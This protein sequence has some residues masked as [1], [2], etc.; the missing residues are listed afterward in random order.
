MFSKWFGDSGDTFF[1]AVQSF[2]VQANGFLESAFE[3]SNIDASW[4][5]GVVGTADTPGMLSIWMPI[6]AIVIAILV[7]IQIA[8]AAYK[9]SGIG[10]LRAVA[11]AAF[12]IPMTYVMIFLVQIFSAG[13]DQATSY[14]LQ[15][16]ATE[17]A[18]VFMKV[19]GVQ[20]SDGE[21]VAVNAKYDMWAAVGE[22]TGGLS[23]LAPLLLM[24]L[25]WL[26]SIVLGVVM[27]LRSM[28]IVILSS[29]AGWAVA[30]LSSDITKSWF[31]G[32]M[33]LIVGLLLAKPF[34]A[35]VI[36]L[37]ATIFN[38]ADSGMQ[39][40]AGLA[41]LFIAICMPFLAISFVNFTPAGSVSQQDQAFGGAAST[42][43]R[44]GSR[45]IRTI[46]RFRK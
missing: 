9:G 30:A 38:F 36:V 17:N 45:G 41:G 33:K 4:W 5:A 19:F 11:G 27:S 18:S 20:I 35:S 10:V 7:F 39:F 8:I 3:S 13:T 12:A 28:G 40:F 37:A 16:G 43:A 6:M 25:I 34:A 31:P 42:V 44:G 21:L 29:F 2:A 22:K 26:M 15:M 46:S 24:F 23:M 14:I 32:W 1:E